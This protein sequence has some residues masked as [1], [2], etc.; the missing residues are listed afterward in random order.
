MSRYDPTLF[1]WL[2]G[3]EIL[4]PQRQGTSDEFL[5]AY[6]YIPSIRRMQFRDTRT[7]RMVGLS[8][9]FY[10]VQAATDVYYRLIPGRS[11]RD[12]NKK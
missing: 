9:K 5:M 4:F 10:D 2:H 8:K 11:A 1:E 3:F 7:N 12:T 6:S